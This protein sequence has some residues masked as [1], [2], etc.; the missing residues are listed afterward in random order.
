MA[1]SA[2]TINR[3]YNWKFDQAVYALEHRQGDVVATPRETEAINTLSEAFGDSGWFG[4]VMGRVVQ[5]AVHD[6]IGDID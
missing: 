3:L 2:D 1:L 4:G 6:L 5:L